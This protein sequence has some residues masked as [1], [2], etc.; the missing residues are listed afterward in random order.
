[1]RSSR[2]RASGRASQG[3]DSCPAARLRD[4]MTVGNATSFRH[5]AYYHDSEPA[6]RKWMLLLVGRHLRPVAR[7]SLHAREMKKLKS[8][9]FYAD[10]VGDGDSPSV[11]CDCRRGLKMLCD[12]MH[13]VACR[14]PS[15][16]RFRQR[17]E[18]SGRMRQDA[19][20]K[21]RSL[22]ITPGNW[23]ATQPIPPQTSLTS[24][25]HHLQ[26]VHFI[27]FSGPLH[28]MLQP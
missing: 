19:V 14:A 24:L 18:E 16:A 12:H 1:M 26:Y 13:V 2:G 4:A 9:Q 5:T 25:Q 6:W 22:A 27:R 8:M 7:T 23:E 15:A 21:Q 11:A 3:H 17:S 28:D 20:E 10:E